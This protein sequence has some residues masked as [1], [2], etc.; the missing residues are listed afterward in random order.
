MI[1]AQQPSKALSTHHQ[2]TLML[3]AGLW[4]NE[5]VP[6]PLMIPLVVE[7]IQK[8]RVAIVNQI[9]L[10][11]EEAIQRIRQLPGTLR[12]EGSSRMGGDARK[13]HPPCTEFHHHQH[14]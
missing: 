7:A 2:P 5:L 3:H 12:H 10:T 11:Q 4:D 6:K 8:F 14:I 13:M 1:I 9:P